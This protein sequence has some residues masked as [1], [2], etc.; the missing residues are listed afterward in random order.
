M[1]YFASIVK[2]SINT[3]KSS[4]YTPFEI[5][6][7]EK[8]LKIKS[9]VYENSTHTCCAFAIDLSRCPNLKL[10][11]RLVT[12]IDLTYILL[13]HTSYTMYLRSI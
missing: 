5:R 12:D 10:P 1:V 7:L 9:H 13:L 4:S 6:G 3:N 11:S 2:C 8:I